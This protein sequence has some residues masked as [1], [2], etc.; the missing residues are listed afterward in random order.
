[1]PHGANG[2]NVLEK[3]WKTLSTLKGLSLVSLAFLH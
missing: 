3:K 1:M 2:L